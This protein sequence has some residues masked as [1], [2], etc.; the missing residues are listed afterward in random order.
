MCG[1]PARLARRATADSPAVGRCCWRPPVAVCSACGRER[2]CFHA[3][4]PEPLCLTCTKTS[5]QKRCMDCGEMTPPARRVAGGVV[6]AACDR[7]PGS[8]TGGCRCGQIALLV[9][10]LC[11]ACRLRDRVAELAGGADRDAAVALAPFLDALAAAP[12]AA[13]MLRWIYVPGFAVCRALLAGELPV[14]GSPGS[15]TSSAARL[16]S[17][18]NTKRCSAVIARS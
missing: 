5:R 18:T 3:D 4:G 13:S 7:L 15:P 1:Q 16:R 14:S 10:G 17:V 12:N 2:P 9:R 6:C 11:V 8:T